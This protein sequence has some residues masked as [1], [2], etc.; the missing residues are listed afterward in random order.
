MIKN[1]NI[2]IISSIFIIIATISL[3]GCVFRYGE[4]IY[5]YSNFEYYVEENTILDISNINGQIDVDGWENDT[6]LLHFIKATNEKYGEDEFDKVE[7]NINEIGNKIIVETEYLENRNHVSV[8]MKIN[9][10]NH[11]IV[12]SVNTQNG[13]IYISNLKGDVEANT[14]NGPIYIN[15]V[16]GF[17]EAIAINGPISVKDTTGVNDIITNNGVICAEINDINNDISIKTDNGNI[18]AY[19]NPELNL[20]LYVESV[21]TGGISLNDLLSSLEIERLD[22]HHIEAVLGLGGNNINIRI[23]NGFIN[24]YK[25]T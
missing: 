23:V 9:V 5:E 3:T 14:K 21:S 2:I 8:S 7:I 12:G 13:G 20:D 19:I 22:T 11:V 4:N 16:D 18:E 6:I 15:N 25:L 24:L 10:P 17:V 1:K